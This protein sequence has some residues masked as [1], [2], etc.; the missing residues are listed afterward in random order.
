[1]SVTLRCP[2][3]GTTRDAAGECDACHD[4]A[5]RYF[6]DDHVPGV[7]LKGPTCERCGATFGARHPSLPPT[8]SRAPARPR[9]TPIPPI[10]SATPR[11]APRLRLRPTAVAA[12][13]RPSVASPSPLD[14]RALPWER[15][16]VAAARAR[17]STETEPAGP[18]LGR[19]RAVVGCLV[20]L[21]ILAV[22]L[23][24]ALL[25]AAFFFA[26]SVLPGLLGN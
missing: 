22:L 14:A 24:V 11:A 5:V 13:S 8:V 3:C 15:L 18:A 20:R 7:W 9:A 25:V 10:A 1:M 6:C 12:R 17:S 16:L 2:S 23:V 26:R 19:A 21:G 4:A